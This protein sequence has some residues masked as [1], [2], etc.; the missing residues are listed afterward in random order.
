M[1]WFKSQKEL[2]QLVTELQNIHNE[3]VEKLNK[4]EVFDNSANQRLISFDKSANEFISTSKSKI[5]VTL[6]EMKEKNRILQ[7]RFSSDAG[8]LIKKWKKK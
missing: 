3:Y 2:R 1:K 5:I 6:E 7:E 4:L 8:K